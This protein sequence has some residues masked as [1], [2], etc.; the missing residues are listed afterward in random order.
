MPPSRTRLDPDG[1]YARL[2]LEPSASRGD[3]AA[4]YRARAR[5]LHPDV[6][7]TGDTA[8]FVAVKL[9]YDVLSDGPRREA[10][11]RAARFTALDD[12][13]P[14][15]LHSR[16]VYAETTP[17]VRRPRFSDLPIAV[18]LCGGL[19]LS[20][21]VAEAVVNMRTR[22][23]VVTAGITPNAATIKPLS[24]DAHFG[25]LYGPPPVRLAGTPNFYVVPA[26]SPAMLWR[27]DAE[28]GTFSPIRELPPFSAV[29]GIQLVR[30]N[31]MLEVL[32]TDETNGFIDAS[33]LTPGSAE[34][35]RRGYCGYNAG[36]PPF[37]GEVLYH[38]AHGDGRLLLDNRALQPAVLKLR[39]ADGAVVMSVFLAPRGHAEITNVPLGPFQTDFAVGEL[40]SRACDS[41]AAGMRA[42]RLAAPLMVS[43]NTILEIAPGTASLPSEELADQAFSGN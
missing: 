1:Y 8:A 33:H 37:N 10:Y 38:R 12:I 20:V 5:L 18:W 31:G 39:G 42:R 35:A 25:L 2:G 3:I 14:A 4:A 9:A 26:A 17:L 32:V 41:F 29:Q 34:A 6:P 13:E 43:A 16:P 22:T 21:C 7:G 24:A 30:P 23:P 11:D 40:W 19:I 36:S 27:R 15:I 28:R